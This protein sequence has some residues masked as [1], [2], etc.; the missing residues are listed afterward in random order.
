MACKNQRQ[1]QSAGHE[2]PHIARIRVVGMD[3]IGQTGLGL[4]LTT[5]AIRQMVKKGPKKLLA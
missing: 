3:P 4:Q 2:S 5:E 1:L